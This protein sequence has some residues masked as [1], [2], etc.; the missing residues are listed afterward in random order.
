MIRYGFGKREKSADF[1]EFQQRI[2]CDFFANKGSEVR[3]VGLKSEWRLRR[4]R[5]ELT[6]VTHTVEIAE[7]HENTTKLLDN[8]R[9]GRFITKNLVKNKVQSD[10]LAIELSQ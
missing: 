3:F 7:N 4:E 5:N 6:K 8:L 2:L 1:P 9:H 10:A